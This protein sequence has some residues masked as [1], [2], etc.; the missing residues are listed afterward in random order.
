MRTNNTIK[1]SIASTISSIVTMLLGF[2][3]TAFF[4]RILNVEYLGLN[5]LFSNIL[6]MLS[7]FELGIGSAIIYNLYKPIA[8]ND[9]EK[10]KSLMHFYRKAYNIIAISV[11]IC[12]LLILPFLNI[13]V[14][15][16]DIDINIHLV[17]LLYLMSTVSSYLIAYKRSLI[18]ANQKNYIINVVHIF[19]LIILNFTQILIVFLTKNYYLYLIIKIVCQ[20]LENIILNFIANKNYPFLKDK[21]IEKLDKRVEKNIFSK[22]KALVF[23]KIGYIIVTG[24]DNIIIS[25]FFGVITVGL[26]SNYYQIVGAVNTLASQFIN[27][28]TAS[29]GNLLVSKNTSHKIKI[30]KNLRFLN[31]WLATFCATSFLVIIQPFIQVWVGKQYLLDK[32]VVFVIAFNLFQKNMRGTYNTFKDAAGIWEE[33]KF[34][35]ILE[36]TLNIV[37]SI[38]FLKFFEEL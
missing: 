3:S 11:F 29:V 14:G 18:Y 15:D 25:Y 2:I 1:N 13:L 23:H 17:Y 12:G 36:S 37:F 19:Y 28:S 22:V 7:F 31:F 30:F 9:I 33:D 4:I 26:Y 32:I 5:G 24:T 34:I 38:V 8:D 20:L 27:S 6:T 10:V 21:N 16:V 35:P